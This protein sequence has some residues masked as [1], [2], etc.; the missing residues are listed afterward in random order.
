MTAAKLPPALSP[1][2]S[3]YTLLALGKEYYAVDPDYNKITSSVPE[4]LR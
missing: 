2:K 4:A 1:A 3:F